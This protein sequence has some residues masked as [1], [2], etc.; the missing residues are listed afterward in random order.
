MNRLDTEQEELLALLVE[1]ERSV[2]RE[3]RHAFSIRRP[4]CKSG[5]VRLVHAGWSNERRVFEGDIELLAQEGLVNLQHT[6]SGSASF[7][8]TPLGFEYYR[9]LSGRQS[10]PLARVQERVS[11]GLSGAWFRSRYP[12]AY[13]KWCEAEALLTDDASDASASVIGH[14]VSSCPGACK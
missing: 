14:L 13:Q 6:H 4:L 5:G 11:D 1:A 12:S 3:E 8:V 2:P 7:Y 10:E 9:H